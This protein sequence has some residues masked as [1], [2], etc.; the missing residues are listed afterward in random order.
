MHFNGQSTIDINSDSAIGEVYCLAHHLWTENGK[1]MLM[2]M[3]FA[4]ITLTFVKMITGFC[5]TQA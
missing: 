2:V 4:I 5:K 1:R 3:V